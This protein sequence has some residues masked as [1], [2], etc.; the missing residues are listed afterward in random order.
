LGIFF[1][2]LFISIDVSEQYN[3]QA[4][5]KFIYKNELGFLVVYIS[6]Y[7]SPST[8]SNRDINYFA[9]HRGADSN[10]NRDS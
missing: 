10:G 5:D 9:C 3:E 2:Y 6:M 8:Y 1:A 4:I 7:E